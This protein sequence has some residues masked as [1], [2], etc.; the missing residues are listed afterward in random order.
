M[1]EFSPITG[2]GDYMG[3]VPQ[4]DNID[5]VKNAANQFLEKSGNTWAMSQLPPALRM[6]KW[7]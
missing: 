2:F 3:L 7:L 6:V 1:A 4:F 5:E